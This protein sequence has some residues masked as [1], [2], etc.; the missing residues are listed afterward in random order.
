MREG[1]SERSGRENVASGGTS[2]IMG[3]AGTARLVYTL[4]IIFACKRQLK[5]LSLSH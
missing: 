2:R 4:D 5:L 3:E 1:E